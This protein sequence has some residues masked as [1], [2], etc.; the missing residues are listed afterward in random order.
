[1]LTCSG[2][3]ILKQEITFA[4]EIEVVSLPGDIWS[5]PRSTWLTGILHLNDKNKAVGNYLLY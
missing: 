1:M 5:L 4:C 3:D 2:V